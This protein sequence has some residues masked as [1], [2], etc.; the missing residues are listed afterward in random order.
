MAKNKDYLSYIA[1][2]IRKNK[3]KKVNNL[4]LYIDTSGSI[5]PEQYRPI[6]KQFLDVAHNKR[7]F[8]F[9][10]TFSHE[11]GEQYQ[12]RYKGWKSKRCYEHFLNIIQPTTGGTDFV[13]IWNYINKSFKRQNEI[14]IIITD[15]Q[16]IPL[17]TCP[18]HPQNLYYTPILPS[19]ST[20][21]ECIKKNIRT[22]CDH[23]EPIVPNI[24]DHIW[25][26]TEHEVS[27]C[28]E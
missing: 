26:P 22:F 14:S 6:V 20:S 2:I 8:I 10:N 4:H 11:L 23:M 1:A 9:A 17:E 25:I 13:Q 21:V 19:E 5:A 3:K 16:W 12:L 27:T 28:S 18:E 15:F 7:T 24:R